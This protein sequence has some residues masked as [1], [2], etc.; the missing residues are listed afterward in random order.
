[1][2][3][4]IKMDDHEL[5][6]SGTFGEV[7][8]QTTFIVNKIC[9]MYDRR[10]VMSSIMSAEYLVPENEN[11]VMDMTK[12][13]NEFKGDVA[14][15]LEKIE[16]LGNAEGKTFKEKNLTLS[17]TSKEKRQKTKEELQSWLEDFKAKFGDDIDV[18]IEGLFD[19]EDNN[20]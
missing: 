14:R 6:V 19:E 9:S 20:E 10:E 4:V 7:L 1:M 2:R 17:K 11:D 3:Q 12:I 16:M 15:A 8:T 13:I 5:E 18:D